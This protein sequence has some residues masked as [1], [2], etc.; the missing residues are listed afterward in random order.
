MSEPRS[1]LL[2][3][4]NASKIGRSIIADQLIQLR[5]DD[6]NALQVH[7]GYHLED[8]GSAIKVKLDQRVSIDDVSSC[9]MCRHFA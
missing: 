9:V 3:S 7:A 1:K 4:T 8:V 6:L 2:P 5:F